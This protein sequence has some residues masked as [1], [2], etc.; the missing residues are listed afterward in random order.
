[1]TQE[2]KV[3]DTDPYI[4][5]IQ[6]ML[7]QECSLQMV[8][9]GG[10]GPKTRDA[11]Q[12]YQTKKLLRPTG[13]YSPPMAA[14]MDPLITA[15]YLTESSF[16]VAAATLGVPVSS[17]KAVQQVETS[18]SG[19]LN[20]GRSQILFERH[21]FRKQLLAFMNASPNNAQAVAAAAGIPYNP[22]TSTV[23]Q[24]DSALQVSW[25]AVYN[26]TSGGYSGGAKEYDRMNRAALLNLACAQASA[27][28]GLF[29]IMGY[30]FAE[31]GYAS[32]AAFVADSQASESLQLQ[33]FV[34]FILANSN[35]I[36]SLR[37]KN[38]HG[39]AVGYNGSGQQGY[40]QRM[41]QAATYWDLHPVAV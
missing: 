4:K 26:P 15:K 39:F 3:G 25:W 41:Q 38:W 40:D 22:S 12:L 18:G 14:I 6:R 16:S 35:L 10:F 37:A 32:V 9:D 19:F 5:K 36:T 29:Q 30:Q 13:T 24:L 1:M 2:F 33:Q 11:V 31:L 28:W 34:K 21:V 17:V 8:C 20:D 27:S 23:P 7:N